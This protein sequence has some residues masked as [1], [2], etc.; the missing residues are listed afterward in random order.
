[1]Q[2]QSK[3]INL[4]TSGLLC[5]YPLAKAKLKLKKMKTG[6][7][8]RVISTDPSSILDFKVFAETSSYTL[9]ECYQ[10]EN[11]FIFVIRL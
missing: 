3:I 2:K 7:K 8:L 1:M 10:E 6:E 4:D 9:L 5:P 11:K